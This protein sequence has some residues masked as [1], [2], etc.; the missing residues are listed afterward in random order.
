MFS[1][2]VQHRD[3][4]GKLSD[5]KIKSSKNLKT[6]YKLLDKHDSGHIINDHNLFVVIKT[7]GMITW[8]KKIE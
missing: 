8:V 1:L 6:C 4:W 5:I 3:D 2:F 7:N